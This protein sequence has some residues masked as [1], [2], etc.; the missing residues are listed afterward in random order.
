MP[1][2]FNYKKY[3]KRELF[4]GWFWMHLFLEI[5]FLAL[6]FLISWKILLIVLVFYFLQFAIFKNCLINKM[7]FKQDDDAVFLY[8][9][10]KM[11]GWRLNYRKSKILLRYALPVILFILAIIWQVIFQHNPMLVI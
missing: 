11:L 6:P 10:L 3:S 1:K 5:V 4:G 2:D 7:H 8:P 9:Y